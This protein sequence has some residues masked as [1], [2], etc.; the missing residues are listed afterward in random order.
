MSKRDYYEVLGVNRDAGGD[1]IKKS[2]RRLA[3]KYHP[4][5]N[6]AE[7]AQ[8][9]FREAS[10][11]YEVLSN[12]DK[13]AAYDRYG[14]A[15]VDNSGGFTFTQSGDFED[16]FGDLN[17]VFS[18]FFGGMGGNRRRNPNTPQ[19]G[20]DLQYRMQLELA[21]AVGGDTISIKVPVLQSCEDCNGSGAAKGTRKSSCSYCDGTGQ[22]TMNRSFVMLRQTCHHCGGTGQVIS[23]PCSSCG[24]VGRRE[25]ERTLAVKVPPG[26]DEGTQLRMRGKGESGVNDGPDGDLF[27]VFNIRKHPVFTR[28]GINLHCEV[29]ISFSQAALGSE[30]DIPTLHGQERLKVTAG[31]QTGTEFRLRGKGVTSIHHRHEG[32]GDLLVKVMVETPV[33]LSERQR[34]L[35]TEFEQTLGK[36]RKRHSPKGSKWYSAFADFFEKI[37]TR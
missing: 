31:T 33:K 36:N 16:I 35:L 5:R 17:S 28:D 24:G 37:A 2:Y 27:V 1:E 20:G 32:T 6:S 34:E 29:P 26:V 9:K 18:S 22:I 30:I 13:R 21:Q 14:H 8:E 11:A 3:M 12:E 25:K 7:D 4:D 23:N 10:E 15:G 19:Q